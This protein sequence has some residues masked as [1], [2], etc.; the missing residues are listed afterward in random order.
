MQDSFVFLGNE[1]GN[2]KASVIKQCRF[3]KK[4]SPNH[5]FAT[6][7]NRGSG[8]APVFENCLSAI[9]E[10]STVHIGFIAAS[11]GSHVVGRTYLFPGSPPGFSAIRKAA[12]R[13]RSRFFPSIWLPPH[14]HGPDRLLKAAE[15]GHFILSL[16]IP[17]KVMVNL[18]PGLSDNAMFEINMVLAINDVPVTLVSASSPWFPSYV[19]ASSIDEMRT[20]RIS[21]AEQSI[22]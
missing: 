5:R 22:T 2:I 20:Y 8:L 4:S 10:Y 12:M 15:I 7:C 19:G 11:S 9:S 21:M 17:P 18:A 6:F 16:G 14:D 3:Y 13:A 1:I